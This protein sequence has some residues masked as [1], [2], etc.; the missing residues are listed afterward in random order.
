M[1][2]K[3]TKEGLIVEVYVKP[4]SKNTKIEFVENKLIFF[5]K[6]QPINGKVNKELVNVLS[7]LFGVKAIIV[8]GFKSNNK[9]LLFKKTD[10]NRFLKIIKNFGYSIDS[11]S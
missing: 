8:S 5:S 1:I 7:N 3:E 4:R 10:K 2:L 11:L 6:K 9:I